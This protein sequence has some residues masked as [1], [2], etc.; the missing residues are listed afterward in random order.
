MSDTLARYLEQG[1]GVSLEFKRCGNQPERDFFETVCSFANRQGGTILLGVRDD[2]TVEGIREESAL[3]IERNIAN[4]LCNPQQFN[5]A[6]A[7]EIE[8]VQHEGRLVLRVWVPMGASVYRF[9]GQVFDRVADADVRLVSDE[10]IT[11]LYIRKKNH[12]S[13]RRVLPFVRTDD[14]RLDLLV[15]I[16]EM[17]ANRRP[18]HP[19]ISLADEELLRTARL[20]A[21]DLETGEWGYTL[22]AVMLLGKDE[23]I[24]DASPVYRTDAVLSRI[25][26]DR[27]DDRLVVTTNLIDAYGQLV[28]WCE[29]WLPD[30]F[31]LEAGV[32]VSARDIIIREL[33]ANCLIHREF[34][35]PYLSRLV[36]DNEGV[37]TRNPS[38][39]L[40]AGPVTPDH[41]EPTP[42]NPIVAHFFAQIGI[43]EELG[44][45]TRNLYKYSALYTGREPRLVDGD[46]F[47]AFV[48]VPTVTSSGPAKLDVGMERSSAKELDDR[49][50]AALRERG[51]AS[52][53][54]LA[55]LTGA[56]QRTVRRHLAQLVENELVAIEGRGR[57]TVYRMAQGAE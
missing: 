55:T 25:D 3:A 16:R 1:E 41:M 30:A 26:A 10:Q 44:S 17:I 43:A 12:Y 21:R 2:G 18:G 31:A 29:R 34:S 13:E 46:F 22:A 47:E 4:V 20:Y 8:R 14:L 33:V 19:W 49:L 9:K 15:R 39:C 7:F 27:Y 11:A 54:D 53:S 51:R 6:P 28:S 23:T 40:Y 42:K 48:P 24:L 35:S 45:G 38:R 36:I 52:A 56:T 32:R 5:V 37:H 50:I 57:S